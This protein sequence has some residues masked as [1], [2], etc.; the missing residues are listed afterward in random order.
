MTRLFPSLCRFA[1]IFWIC[2]HHLLGYVIS[3][4]LHACGTLRCL[5]LAETSSGPVRLRM[6][7]EEIGGT[8]IKFGQVL[9]LQSDI[10]PL[11]YCRELFSLLDRVPPFPF[12][13]VET[14]VTRELGRK[15][16]E[17]YDSFARDPI[18]TGS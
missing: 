9:A 16:Q 10:L 8:F 3:R 1:R 7:L 12:E 13:E 5:R 11:E 4:R 17:I 2:I 6:A 18:A 14:I 15:P